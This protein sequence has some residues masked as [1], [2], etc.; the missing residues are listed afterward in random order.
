VTD[1]LF[2]KFGEIIDNL[3][4]RAID[5]YMKER[6]FRANETFG[7]YEYRGNRGYWNSYD[8]DIR[9]LS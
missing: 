4:R 1:N 7:V 9:Y 6:D 2:E 3:K 5:A 8:S